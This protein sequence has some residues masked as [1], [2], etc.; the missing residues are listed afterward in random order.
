MWLLST[1]ATNLCRGWNEFPSQRLG[2]P[3]NRERSSVALEELRV[4]P[5][6]FQLRWLGHLFRMPPL[7]EVLGMFHQ[8]ENLG[9]WLPAFYCLMSPLDL[10]FIPR[11]P[12]HVRC[13][14]F[15][16][17]YD[18]KLTSCSRPFLCSPTTNI[19]KTRF[20]NILLTDVGPFQKRTKPTTYFFI[21]ILHQ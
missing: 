13:Q 8:K 7:R 15:T 6:P 14:I 11:V 10:S 17:G 21:I 3:R 16:M 18:C 4:Q 5:L 2:T 20:C 12:P 19:Y 9:L 1:M